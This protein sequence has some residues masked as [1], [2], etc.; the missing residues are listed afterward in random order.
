MCLLSPSKLLSL[1]FV[2]LLL[3]LGNKSFLNLN[4]PNLSFD[5]ALLFQIGH[6]TTL[7]FYLKLFFVS[8]FNFA[9]QLFNHYSVLY[10]LGFTHF[11]FL[12]LL[13]PFFLLFFL[14]SRKG[15]FFGRDWILCFFLILHLLS[16]CFF[17]AGWF[18]NLFFLNKLLNWLLDELYALFLFYFVQWL[19]N[20]FLNYSLL[21]FF[22]WFVDLFW[23]LFNLIH[24]WV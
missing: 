12:L 17:F 24:R 20:L 5:R 2:D 16:K 9:R 21:Y 8:L 13:G 18:I 1:F 10:F 19:L 4:R 23:C 7:F 15:L 6:P 11:H 14:Q 22:K 3:F